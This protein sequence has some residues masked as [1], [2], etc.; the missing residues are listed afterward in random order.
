MDIRVKSEN[1]YNDFSNAIGDD[2]ATN[3][4]DSDIE[5]MS[6]QQQQQQSN[7][8]NLAARLNVSDGKFIELLT[9]YKTFLHTQEL[10]PTVPI[11]TV[12]QT[13]LNELRNQIQLNY[14]FKMTVTQVKK[15]LENVKARLK[16]KKELMDEDNRN[17]T[18]K[19]GKLKRFKMHEQ[20]LWNLLVKKEARR[21]RQDN[22]GK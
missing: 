20:K 9:H 15:K 7:A 16:K 21:H 14:G 8:L 17:S 5:D 10:Y 18:R 13:A 4:F 19:G 1:I 6:Q 2:E 22:D 12:K 11:N 3:D